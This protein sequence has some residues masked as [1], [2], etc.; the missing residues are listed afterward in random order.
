MRKLSQKSF[1][2]FN[3]I[4]DEEAN[5][6]SANDPKKDTSEA[7][8]NTFIKHSSPKSSP[9]KKG[10]G[11]PFD[12]S[13]IKNNLE[14]YENDNNYAKRCIAM[15]NAVDGIGINSRN[16]SNITLS[17]RD[18]QSDNYGVNRTANHTIDD[19]VIIISEIVVTNIPKVSWNKENDPYV[20]M[21]LKKFSY[22]LPT[23][24]RAGSKAVWSDMV[25]IAV[26]HCA[27]ASKGT[28]DSSS[29]GYQVGYDIGVDDRTPIVIQFEVY[30]EQL[31]IADKFIGRAEHKQLFGDLDSCCTSTIDLE[32]SGGEVSKKKV[33]SVLSFSITIGSGVPS[34]SNVTERKHSEVSMASSK[35]SG[36]NHNDQ[37]SVYSKTIDPYTDNNVNGFTKNQLSAAADQLFLSEDAEEN[38]TT[39]A[40]RSQSAKAID[41]SSVKEIVELLTSINSFSNSHKNDSP[42]KKKRNSVNNTLRRNSYDSKSGIRSS[43]NSIHYTNSNINSISNDNATVASSI[44]NK[45]NNFKERH[46]SY[47]DARGSN[48]ASESETKP[49]I[50]VREVKDVYD[51]AF[52]NS[53][54]SECSSILLP[55]KEFLILLDALGCAVDGTTS[56]SSSMNRLSKQNKICILNTTSFAV[57]VTEA[58]NSN[59]SFNIGSGLAVSQVNAENGVKYLDML[60]VSDYDINKAKIKSLFIQKVEVSAT[61]A[62]NKQMIRPK[63]WS[64]QQVTQFF[65]ILE[66]GL[67]SLENVN[68]AELM[69]MTDRDINIAIAQKPPLMQTRVRLYHRLLVLLDQWWYR[70]LRPIDPVDSLYNTHALRAV[71]YDKSSVSNTK[72]GSSSNLWQRSIVGDNYSEWGTLDADDIKSSSVINSVGIHVDESEQRIVVEIVEFQKLLKQLVAM[73]RAYAWGHNIDELTLFASTV[74]GMKGVLVE[75]EERNTINISSSNSNSHNRAP[76]LKRAYSAKSDTVSFVDSDTA[77]TVSSSRRSVQLIVD[78]VVDLPNVTRLVSTQGL[79]DLIHCEN[80]E[81]ICTVPKQCLRVIKG[82]VSIGHLTADTAVVGMPV[83]IENKKMLIRMCER[84]EWWDRPDSDLLNAMAGKVG[85]IVSTAEAAQKGRV[86]VKLLDSEVCDA[87]PLE[88]LTK[89]TLDDLAGHQNF[90]DIGRGSSMTKKNNCNRMMNRNESMKSEKQSREVPFHE[91]LYSHSAKNN[92]KKEDETAKPRK[93]S[94]LKQAIEK[95]R[96]SKDRLRKVMKRS[97]GCNSLDNYDSSDSNDALEAIPSS[98][99]G[100]TA[101]AANFDRLNRERDIGKKP[102]KHSVKKSA[103]NQSSPT[104]SD[105]YTHVPALKKIPV[106]RPE[107]LD[108]P[109]SGRLESLSGSLISDTSMMKPTAPTV[110]AQTHQRNSTKQLLTRSDT[111]EAGTNDIK[112]L[113]E[114]DATFL[115]S[116]PHQGDESAPPSEAYYEGRED[117]NQTNDSNRRPASASAASRKA[118]YTRGILNKNKK[119]SNQDDGSNS[120]DYT[121][122]KLDKNIRN[123][124]DRHESVEKSQEILNTIIPPRPTTPTKDQY[125]GSIRDNTKTKKAPPY[126]IKEALFEGIDTSNKS[127]RANTPIKTK[128]T[129]NKLKSEDYNINDSS[130]KYGI[131]ADF[132]EDP[133]SPQQKK[134]PFSAPSARQKKVP[135]GNNLYKKSTIAKSDLLAQDDPLPDDGSELDAPFGVAGTSFNA[136]K[137]VD[138]PSANVKKQQERWADHVQNYEQPRPNKARQP[139]KSHRNDKKPEDN[140]NGYDG[141]TN[142]IELSLNGHVPPIATTDPTAKSS[143]SR[144]VSVS[145]GQRR[146]NPVGMKNGAGGGNYNAEI[147]DSSP[148]SKRRRNFVDENAANNTE[149]KK[150]RTLGEIAKDANMT[151][152]V[153]VKSKKEMELSKREKELLRQEKQRSQKEANHKESYLLKALKK[154]GVDTNTLQI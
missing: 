107:V 67:E 46:I 3:S 127:P 97:K 44:T 66:C 103:P 135:A 124:I 119:N 74:G 73:N 36:I 40:E 147:D 91:R 13:S 43:H 117:N 110:S 49:Q 61:K 105:A 78:P 59:R 149:E 140:I 75:D 26:D 24:A 77:T 108:N 22:R 34:V 19:R 6:I 150:L 23:K 65:S 133:E 51:K 153:E 138:G 101:D 111:M 113:T 2:T 82:S 56:D 55:N 71:S 52:D 63:D 146:E 88:A 15:T 95:S 122:L 20:V 99:Y 48:P 96:K 35:F 109:G 14:V 68:G 80:N 32:L 79:K 62:G 102:R 134:R 70:G 121:W 47:R 29:G 83:V 25:K 27:E 136:N 131:L 9:L 92:Y 64:I 148:S 87:L 53:Y 114:E 100:D 76:P 104:K 106:A 144:P 123:H 98:G 45:S 8:R 33:T 54:Q 72:R 31:A 132:T 93:I 37:S 154:L 89:A 69:D 141:S 90:M 30:N 94:K 85:E 115:F 50:V 120:A 41:N 125:T 116:A 5:C 11:S 60:I 130:L 7:V 137:A 152:N 17:P 57:S 86:G 18:D 139:L 58:I 42:Q 129:S 10:D 21:S 1:S 81:F 4:T 28:T 118:Y 142:C 112:V 151:F 12:D 145:S 143:T 38:T 39:K 16:V 128:K 126:H 84:Y